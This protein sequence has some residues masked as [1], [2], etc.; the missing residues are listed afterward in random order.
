MQ[1]HPAMSSRNA[2]MGVGARI[3][4]AEPISPSSAHLVRKHVAACCAQTMAM[5][6]MQAGKQFRFFHGCHDMS[7][8]SVTGSLS[9]VETQLSVAKQ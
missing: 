4:A 5:Y 2:I 1:L 8:V 6:L 7:H 9:T 3:T